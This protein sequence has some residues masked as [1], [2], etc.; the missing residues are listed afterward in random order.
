MIDRRRMPR[1]GFTLVELLVVIAIIGILLAITTGVIMRTVMG[2]SQQA[3]TQ[4]DMVALAEALERFKAEHGGY[5]PPSSLRGTNL[6]N[7]NVLTVM[8]KLFPGLNSKFN[9]PTQT[10]TIRVTAALADL[11]LSIST[12]DLQGDQCMVLFL[13]GRHVMSSGGLTEQPSG[14]SQNP[15][16]PFIS[17]KDSTE[18]VSA[19]TSTNKSA[20]RAGERIPPYFKFDTTRF[21]QRNQS[22]SIA[23]YGDG[24]FGTAYNNVPQNTCYAYFS[25]S[26][27]PLNP[28]SKG[29]GSYSDTDCNRMTDAVGSFP[30]PFVNLNATTR[31]AIKFEYVNPKSFQIISAGPDTLFGNAYKFPAS[32]SG[33]DIGANPNSLDNYVNFYTGRLGGS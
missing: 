22:V 26:F 15:A 23:S 24:Y 33:S 14:F 12:V 31:V 3:E 25:T 21:Y 20:T 27:V 19:A 4:Q 10:A 11:G 18:S 32:N 16:R 6:A 2:R 29:V 13:A 28:A 5:Y 9:D 8:P 30:T 7:S 1:T 17:P